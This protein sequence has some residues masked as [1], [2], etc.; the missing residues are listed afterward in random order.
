MHVG[1]LTLYNLCCVPVPWVRVSVCLCV[2]ERGVCGADGRERKCRNDSNPTSSDL[3][4]PK[5]H[6]SNFKNKLK[7]L[8]DSDS[9]A[10]TGISSNRLKWEC[11]SEHLMQV[12]RKQ[13]S[14]VALYLASTNLMVEDQMWIIFY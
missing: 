1:Y 10:A 9:R 8:C 2:C 14:R 12:V 3:Q 13:F 5:G 4:V 7:G 6:K 11:K